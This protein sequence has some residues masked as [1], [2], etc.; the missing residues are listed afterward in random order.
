MN[1]EQNNRSSDG[2]PDHWDDF[3]NELR[4]LVPWTPPIIVLRDEADRRFGPGRKNGSSAKW[5]SLA[6]G[7]SIGLVF[8][9]LLGVF[10]GPAADLE[11]SEVV[12]LSDPQE[13][14][15]VR[16]TSAPPPVEESVHAV[17]TLPAAA[18]ELDGLIGRYN[19]RAEMFARLPA[20]LPVAISP[21]NESPLVSDDPNSLFRL[22]ESLK[23]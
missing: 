2:L 16:E 14:E 11:M 3:E 12:R 1:K 22:R 5:I 23:L 13:L 17:A 8:G 21:R 18:L 19:D 6:L 4:R 9:C 20:A 10:L 7:L 15:N